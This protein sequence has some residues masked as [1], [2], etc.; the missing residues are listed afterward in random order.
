[1][2]AM[3]EGIG[4]NSG[5]GEN[6]CEDPWRQNT[7]LHYARSIGL[8]AMQARTKMRGGTVSGLAGGT[9]AC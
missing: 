8:L 1:M 5:L 2:V 9:A 7:F 4:E 3:L 6:P